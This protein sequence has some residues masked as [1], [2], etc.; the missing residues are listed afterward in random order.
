MGVVCVFVMMSSRFAQ[1]RN[2]LD[3]RA[4]FLS[5]TT[6][7]LLD[8]GKDRYRNGEFNEASRSYWGA[9]ERDPGTAIRFFRKE[10]QR[11]PHNALLLYWLG[12]A[13][14]TESEIPAAIETFSDVVALYPHYQ[15]AYVQLA[16]T[17]LDESRFEDARRTLDASLAVEKR[18]AWTHAAYGHLYAVQGKPAEAIPYYEAALAIDSSYT[19]ARQQ[20]EDLYRTTRTLKG[21]GE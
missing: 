10:L 18:H 7:F 11:D 16:Y 19:E 3:P 1:P 9:V 4:A 21:G 17:Y 13:L 2:V 14:R 20:L 12:V 15:D 6:Q 5:V 8:G